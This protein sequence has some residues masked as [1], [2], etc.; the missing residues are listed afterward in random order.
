MDAL[1]GLKLMWMSGLSG[2]NFIRYWIRNSYA[3]CCEMR[4]K[5]REHG[6]EAILSSSDVFGKKRQEGMW[7]IFC[8]M[9]LPACFVQEKKN[10]GK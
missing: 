2:D 10:M 1:W 9:V 6:K 8:Y 4:I 3:I 5:K 7:L